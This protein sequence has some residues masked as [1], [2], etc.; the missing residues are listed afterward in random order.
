MANKN[1]G[2]LKKGSLGMLRFIVG[3][4]QGSLSLPKRIREGHFVVIT[5]QGQER[6]RFVIKLLYLN[7]PEFLKLLNRAEEEFGFSQEGALEL[8]CRPDELLRILSL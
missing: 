7:N 5:T 4:L 6:K 8:P 3:K 1:F 2:V